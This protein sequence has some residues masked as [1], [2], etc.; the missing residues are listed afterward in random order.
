MEAQSALVGP[1]CAVDLDPEA[2]V[3]LHLAAVV[4]PRH[5]E[6]DLALRFADALDDLV[7]AEF[8]IL[9]QHRAERF[10]HLADRLMEFHF[11]GIAPDHFLENR[12]EFFVEGMRHTGGCPEG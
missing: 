9:H 5:A 12:F 3:D 2:A 1:Q 10:Q 11:A 6:N 4:L 7:L 8:R